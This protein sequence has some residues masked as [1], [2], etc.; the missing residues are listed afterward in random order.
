M[1]RFHLELTEH[2]TN[3]YQPVWIEATNEWDAKQK[4]EEMRVQGELTSRSGDS[5]DDVTVIV[6][7]DKEPGET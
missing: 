1:P 3:T 7:A 5:I 6:L 4:L 2:I